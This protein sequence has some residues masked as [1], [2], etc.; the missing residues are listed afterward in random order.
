MIATVNTPGVAVD[1]CAAD[2]LVIVASND[3]Q[4]NNNGVSV[5][6]VFA[7]LEPRVIARVQTLDPVLKVTCSRSMIAA[8]TGV[9]GLE[10]I[11]VTDPPAARLLR[12]LSRFELGGVTT[13]VVAAGGIAYVG[14][15]TGEIV[16]VD[17][18]QATVLG[19]V[20][21]GSSSVDDLHIDGDYLYALAGGRLHAL[22]PAPED[23]QI[24]HSQFTGGTEFAI[25]G[26]KAWLISDLRMSVYDVS[27]PTAPFRAG[28]FTAVR[29]FNGLAL[30]GSGLAVGAAGTILQVTDDT[31]HNAVVFDVTDPTQL[32]ITS[33]FA[34]PG[35][36][37][38]VAI[39]NGLAYL[40]DGD[41]GLQV[42]SFAPID[43]GTIAPTISLSANFSL[44]PAQAEEGQRLRITAD[45]TDDVLVRNVE[46]YVDGQRIA[47]DGSFPF[48]VNFLAPLRRN[49]QTVVVQA[50]T[51]DTR[52]NATATA[53]IVVSLT[54]DTTPPSITART[55]R[56]G[57]VV[58]TADLIGAFFSEPMEQA[59]LANGGLALFV[60][61]SPGNFAPFPGGTL[62]FRDGGR[63][64]FLQF[65]SLPEGRYQV[66]I[67]G[68]ATDRSLTPIAGPQVWQFVRYDPGGIDS[69]SDGV[70]DFLEGILNTNPNFDQ[71][72][73]SDGDGLSDAGEVLLRL[74]PTS[75]DSD[76]DGQLD[77]EEDADGDGLSNSRELALGTDL[78]NPDTDA[79]GFVDGEEVLPT[80]TL[81]DPLDPLSTPLRAANGAVSMD[82]L[83]NFD[84][85]S[86]T[87]VPSLQNDGNFD[88]RSAS[89][90]VSVQN[91]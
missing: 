77:G 90:V 24:L 89:G 45:V 68:T 11:D 69:D 32:P 76:G 60:E 79:D 49:Q 34:T 9:G 29:S 58:A 66:R 5:F 64:A 54:P 71:N 28:D 18:A 33:E 59:S 14:L 31:S 25:G 21:L 42:V 35:A 48:E 26:G 72:A 88:P 36:T 38:A 78:F 16:T 40:A 65:A 19:R 15:N 1:I 74:D 91:N 17:L 56:V 7:A 4:G 81:S 55:P 86:A 82:N 70:P 83:G 2:N 39:S 37:Q 30:S 23:P 62:S 44:A 50:R 20:S 61:S 53:P 67:A 47:S 63:G 80:T 27:T 13:D 12:R 87:G 43:T 57:G 3:V 41:V 73:D 22:T 84:P 46:F 10:I 52:G 85:Q 8:A 75:A 6:N 51:V